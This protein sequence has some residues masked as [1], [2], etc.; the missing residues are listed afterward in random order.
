MTDQQA[1][2]RVL[3]A[4]ALIIASMLTEIFYQVRGVGRNREVSSLFTI[5]GGVGVGQLLVVGFTLY[6]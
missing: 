4:A 3:I 1:G 2:L 6:N 5:L